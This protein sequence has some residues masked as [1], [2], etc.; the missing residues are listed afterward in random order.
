[1]SVAISQVWLYS[2]E[3]IPPIGDRTPAMKIVRNLYFWMVLGSLAFIGFSAWV[4]SIHVSRED[5]KARQAEDD[6]SGDIYEHSHASEPMP[7]FLVGFVTAC[8][9]GG[10]WYAVYVQM[11]P[12]ERK[13]ED[14]RL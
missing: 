12:P 4:S 5:I 1:M 6:E 9:V 8:I 13:D 7:P 10:C 14:K 11:H 3:D 2:V